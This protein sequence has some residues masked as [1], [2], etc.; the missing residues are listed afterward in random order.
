MAF[1]EMNPQVLDEAQKS[2]SG[3][4]PIFV[5]NLLRFRAEA[6]YEGQSGFAPCSGKEAYYERYV[7][8]FRKLTEGSSIQLVWL[9]MVLAPFVVPAGER[10][11]QIAIVQYP[12]FEV[13]RNAV[14][15]PAYAAEASPHR[16]AALED[17]RLIAS[18]KVNLAP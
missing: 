10:W 18:E 13:F 7:P 15:S 9:G 8:A 1:I 6:D 14:G 5:L 17:W 3:K 12:S 4:G 2:M 11:D 16:K